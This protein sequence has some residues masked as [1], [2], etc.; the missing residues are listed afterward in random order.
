[1]KRPADPALLVGAGTGAQIIGAA[2]R[3]RYRRAD[4]LP[5][6]HG[7]GLEQKQPGWI[8]PVAWRKTGEADESTE[9][10]DGHVQGQEGESKGNLAGCLMRTDAPGLGLR[11]TI[12]N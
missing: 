5:P 12:G 4:P 9:V 3:S 10:R 8:L 1:M 2:G 6:C 11:K 7:S